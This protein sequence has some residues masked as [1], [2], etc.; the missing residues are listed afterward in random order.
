[1]LAGIM[2][3]LLTFKPQ[4]F[5]LIII[6]LLA[7]RQKT[8]ALATVG[9]A[10]GVAVA[11]L[12]IFGFGAWEAFFDAAS[13][14]SDEVYSGQAPV[15]KMQSIS[16]VLVALGLSQTVTQMLQALASLAAA[17]FVFWLWAKDEVP[18]EYKAAALAIAVL[19]ASPYSYHYD[20]TIMGLAVLWIG[21]RINAEGWRLGDAEVLLLAWLTPFLGPLI[22]SG[23]LGFSIGPAVMIALL[24]ILV[25]RVRPSQPIVPQVQPVPGSIA[26]R[27]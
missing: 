22:L 27:P 2:L 21:L 1:V 4:F 8:A 16:A 10:G 23:Y 13:R 14:S 7:G 9:T 15:E 12:A 11:S 20:L 17:A 3:G 25:R 6:A 5:P 24:A 18:I 19:L 26:V